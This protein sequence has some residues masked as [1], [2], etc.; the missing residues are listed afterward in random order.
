MNMILLSRIALLALRCAQTCTIESLLVFVA[1]KMRERRARE[2]EIAALPFVRFAAAPFRSYVHVLHSCSCSS[3][4][5]FLVVRALLTSHHITSHDLAGTRSFNSLRVDSTKMCI[6][7][8]LAYRFIFVHFSNQ[9]CKRVSDLVSEA[10]ACNHCVK[11]FKRDISYGKNILCTSYK[12]Y[13]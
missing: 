9:K 13:H 4:P 10:F 1:Q 7:K 11:F 3:F 5:S 8:T 2:R 6:I 12:V